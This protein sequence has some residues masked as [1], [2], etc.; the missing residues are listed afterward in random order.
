M[1]CSDGSYSGGDGISKTATWGSGFLC[2]RLIEI[3]GLQSRQGP[4]A[5]AVCTWEARVP[6]VWIWGVSSMHLDFLHVAG[7][8]TDW[9]GS[10]SEADS[11]S[12]AK[13]FCVCHGSW[14]FII[15]FV[16]VHLW[17]LSWARGIQSTLSC[18]ISLLFNTLCRRGVRSRIHGKVSKPW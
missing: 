14:R 9:H 5:M 6:T 7:W 11:F 18:P 13:E 12:P 2:T 3:S 16:R 4:L 17:N 1:V 15:V 8:L 10:M